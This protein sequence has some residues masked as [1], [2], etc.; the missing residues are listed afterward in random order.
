VIR[1]L[2]LAALATAVPFAA[3]AQYASGRWGSVDVGAERY[4]PDVDSDFGSPGPY[5]RMFGG[6]DRWMFRLGISKALYTGMG[7]LEAGV[8]TGYFEDSADALQSDGSRAPVETKF[9]IIPS[10]LAL[11]YRFDWP[12]ER[13]R[14]PLAPYVRATLER[15]NWWVSDG[16]GETESGATNGWSATAG[17]AFLLDILDPGS[18]RDLDRD[19]GVNHTYLFFEATKSSV[20]DF[21]SSS[22]W[23]LSDEDFSFGGGLLFVF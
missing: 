9:R 23:D 3:G 4:R 10:S 17:L 15:Y 20:D 7:S 18:A 2:V 22:S 13:H 11:T 1:R 5:E 21:G 8:R 6:S 14:I 16:D 19:A 12:V